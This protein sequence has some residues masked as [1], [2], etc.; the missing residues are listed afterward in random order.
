MDRS[1]NPEEFD[2][3][4]FDEYE[5]YYDLPL[6][7]GYCFYTAKPFEY[8]EVFI[9]EDPDLVDLKGNGLLTPIQPICHNCCIERIKNGTCDSLN[10]SIF[11][12]KYPKI[13]YPE[14]QEQFTKINFDYEIRDNAIISKNSFPPWAYIFN[15]FPS[16]LSLDNE[17]SEE[18]FLFLLDSDK[19]T[20]LGLNIGEELYEVPFEIIDIFKRDYR[21]RTL[22]Y[23]IS[24]KRIEE[25]DEPYEIFYLITQFFKMEGN[26]PLE[27]LIIQ[28]YDSKNTGLHYIYDPHQIK[29]IYEDLVKN[30]KDLQDLR[31]YF[32]EI[33]LRKRFYDD[34][35]VLKNEYR[36]KIKNEIKENLY[37]AIEKKMNFILFPEYCFPK[38]YITYLTEFS[39]NNN[40]WI[41][42]G[43]ERF[44]GE[45]DLDLEKNAAFIISPKNGPRP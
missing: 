44:S 18:D 26:I 16:E 22:N 5:G 21:Y 10:C 32:S 27:H 17:V 25:E 45:F 8:F 28:M 9:C 41:I 13:R 31:V 36:E 30:D 38:D 4:N 39:K 20:K 12:E 1:D 19:K 34:R 15:D 3:E 33:N 35:G 7:C 14:I 37:D 42:G 29:I 43:A 24:S 23:Y 11:K 6:K 2:D 40:V